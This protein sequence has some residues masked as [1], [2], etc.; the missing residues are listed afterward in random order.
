M[1]FK[2]KYFR[3][4]PATIEAINQVFFIGVPC[5]RFNDNDLHK[6]GIVD[7]QLPLSLGTNFLPSK[8][9][10]FSTINADGQ[11]VIRKDLP[12]ETFYQEISYKWKEWHGP[13]QIEREGTKSI[14]RERYQ[15]QRLDAPNVRITVS[16]I[17]N[18]LFFLIKCEPNEDNLLHKLNLVLEL[19]SE[20]DVHINSRNGLITLPHNL[21]TVDWTILKSGTMTADE[22]KEAV[23]KSISPKIKSTLRPVI[24]QR[25]NYIASF[26]PEVTVI[27]V[28]G[29]SG[30]IIHNFPRLAI[31]VLESEFPDN[32]T[33]IFDYKDWEPLSK[34][35]K[36][37]IIRNNL[38]KARIIHD[39]YWK[40]KIYKLLN[41][42]IEDNDNRKKS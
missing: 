27:G 11:V 42:P 22:I 18:E 32:A 29:Y 9:G 25:L 14:A 35:S 20:F 13:D 10:K 38:E 1:S 12:K 17:D 28:A 5:S 4:I 26:N 37:E 36:T 33:Y 23:E 41:A 40:E 21:K 31:S 2:K 3:K 24:L 34:L 6:L 16:E 39:E 15:R 8:I 7:D 19:F 30:Y